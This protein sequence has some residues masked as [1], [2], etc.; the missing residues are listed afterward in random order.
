M[1]SSLMRSIRVFRKNPAF[2]LAAVL[3]LAVG[4]GA[5]TAI[6]SVIE[7]ILLRPLPYKDPKSLVQFWNTYLPT[8]PKGPNSA[9]DFREFR[10]KAQSF[11]GMEAY[12]DIPEGLNLTGQGEPARLEA[13]YATSGLFPMLGIQPVAGRGFTSEEDNAG[14]PPA[15]LISSNLWRTRFG[16]DRAAIGRMLT[17]DGRGYLLAGVLPDELHLAP[18]TDVWFPMGEYN[19]GP[20]VYRYHQFNKARK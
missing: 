18:T 9:G 12:I 3:T 4:I 5:N 15:V 7:S 2:A 13:R 6:F 20:D 16:A 11:S 10:Q 19:P 17:M 1:W 8:I 14:S